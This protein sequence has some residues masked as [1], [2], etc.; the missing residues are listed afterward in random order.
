MNREEFFRGLKGNHPELLTKLN[1]LRI[2]LGLTKLY[3]IYIDEKEAVYGIH[4]SI[5]SDLKKVLEALRQFT[6]ENTGIDYGSENFKR[7]VVYDKEEAEVAYVLTRALESL[8]G[9][10]LGI[11]EIL[12][13]NEIS[14]EILL[15]ID[16]THQAGIAGA[17][18][19]YLPWVTK[20]KFSNEVEITITE[21]AAKKIWEIL[22]QENLPASAGL[23][24]RVAPG[25]CQGMQ[26][27]IVPNRQPNDNDE[28]IEKTFKNNEESFT[29]R[30]FIDSTSI[31]F[32][33]GSV[34]DYGRDEKQHNFSETFLIINPN[35]KGSCGC[36]K[37]VDFERKDPNSFEV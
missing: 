32:L 27:E 23:R 15:T 33:K 29:V 31:Q 34:I 3:L 4:Y 26:Y 25:G 9:K 12:D 14:G 21:K 2:N 35:E 24:F 11:P 37:S 22:R 6:L 5:K 17:I 8:S 30:M 7:V 1:Q 36:G 18:R 10:Y 16:P 20:V 13:I 19:G 28:V